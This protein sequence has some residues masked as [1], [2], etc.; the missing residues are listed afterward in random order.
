MKEIF[1]E[2]KA[3][4]TGEWRGEG[5]AKFPTI[6]ATAYS[7]VLTFEPDAD[8]DLVRFEQK[9]R[10]KN[11][12]A[13]NGKTVFW[14]TGFIVLK[15]DKILLISAQSGGRV[16]TYELGEFKDNRLTFNSIIISNDIKTVCSQRVFH[17]S[18]ANL[19]YELNM[20][21]KQ[22]VEFQNHLSAR[23]EKF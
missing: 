6:T 9:T 4:V 1:E 3:L 10:Y 15:E 18:A 7:E 14:D 5:Y 11:Q 12:T 13:D 17:L 2:L 20:S 19:N 23:L 8:K 22:A 16:E 21:T